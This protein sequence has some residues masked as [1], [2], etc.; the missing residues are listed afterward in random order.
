MAMNSCSA[1]SFLTSATPSRARSA[2]E[3][4]GM[5]RH[6]RISATSG[7]ATTWPAYPATTR[8]V[9]G[10]ALP[11]R[12]DIVISAGD[13]LNESMILAALFAS[14]SSIPAGQRGNEQVAG[15]RD[16]IYGSALGTAGA[17]PYRREK[18]RWYRP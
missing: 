2:G 9:F 15:A 3:I 5:E 6:Q 11:E 1:V 4:P 16:A 8:P 7:C 17:A 18:W 10:N 14:L 13:L 12:I